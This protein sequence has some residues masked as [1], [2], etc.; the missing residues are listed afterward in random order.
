[1]T[2]S[3]GACLVL[4]A[5]CAVASD[6]PVVVYARYDNELPP[7]VAAEMRAEVS[8]I[9]EPTGYTVEWRP[10]TGLRRG[11]V[12]N[13]LVVVTFHGRCEAEGLVKPQPPRG[14][15]GWTHVSDGVVLPFAELDCGR[16]YSLLAN[17]M[18]PVPEP[19]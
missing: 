18:L 4:S 14:P 6:S 2:K 5:V 16:V 7:A 15:L 19:E 9:M 13:E 1:M 8:T 11:D 3:L 17:G 10:L 12:V